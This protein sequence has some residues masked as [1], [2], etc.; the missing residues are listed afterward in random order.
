MTDGVKPVEAGVNTEKTRHELPKHPVTQN[1]T[2]KSVHFKRLL[3][4]FRPSFGRRGRKR[5]KTALFRRDFLRMNVSR[6]NHLNDL[7][8]QI[9]VFVYLV[10]SGYAVRNLPA[11]SEQKRKRLTYNH[12]DARTHAHARTQHTK[13]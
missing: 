3:R 9:G 7:K 5:L 8:K 11:E 10:L 13:P 1:A 4:G 6:M 12:R 2:A